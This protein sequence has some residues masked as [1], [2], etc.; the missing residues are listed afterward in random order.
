M[1][2]L[3]EQLA[4]RL[5]AMSDRDRRALR[6]GTIVLAPLLVISGVAT[7]VSENQ[8]TLQLVEAKLRLLS[9]LPAA[10]DLSQRAQR[11]GSEMSLSLEM[12][13]KRILERHGVQATVDLQ[14]D[15]SVR[16]RADA[17]A[18]D[19]LIECLGDF[20]AASVS[21]RRGTLTS[22]DSGRVDVEWNLQSSSP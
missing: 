18:F 9:D 8:E 5:E 1:T 20:E 14:P 7:V 16:V 13:V 2:S 21:I 10:R 3:R 19:A 11:M 17:A 15:S 4:D 6:L 22:V 12:R